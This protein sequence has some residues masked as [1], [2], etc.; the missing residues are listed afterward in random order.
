[1]AYEI[2]AESVEL[3]G[4]A[5]T[6]LNGR[7][8]VED[9]QPWRDPI[10]VIGNQRRS[11]RTNLTQL[12]SEDLRFGLGFPHTKGAVPIEG[13]VGDP[14]YRGFADSEAETRFL[15]QVTLP[16]LLED[17]THE[18]DNGSALDHSYYRFFSGGGRSGSSPVD[19]STLA[20]SSVANESVSQFRGAAGTDDWEEIQD[21]TGESNCIIR[22][23]FMH[24]GVVFGMGGTTTTPWTKI[25]KISA[26]GVASLSTPTT[27]V[28]EPAYS[29]VSHRDIIVTANF[30][31]TTGEIEI[32]KSSDD[33]DTF[34]QITGMQA[35]ADVGSPRLDLVIY[36]DASGAPAVYLHTNT[37]LFLLDFE[38]DWLEEI[39]DFPIRNAISSTMTPPPPVVV[40]GRL[41]LARGVKLIEFHYSGAW[42]D[43]S[44]V[45]QARVPTDKF[46]A[47]TEVTALADAGKELMVAFSG[48]GAV[49]SVWS[50][51]GDGFH[52]ITKITGSGLID[53]HDIIVTYSNTAVN[54][55]HIVYTEAGATDNVDFKR[56]ERVLEEP[57]SNTSKK[58]ESTGFVTLPVMDGGMA[59]VI[60][61]IV[62]LGGNFEDLSADETV[63]ITIDL[64]KAGSFGNTLTYDNTISE[65]TQK[66]ASG[67]GLEANTWQLKMTLANS[68]NT[69]SPVVL[70][71]VSYFEKLF[72]DLN[73]Y[74][75]D[76]DVDATLQSLQGKLRKGAAQSVLT[77]LVTSRKK[78]PLLAFKWGGEDIAGGT[79]P[80]Y[81]RMENLPH[82]DER[83]GQTTKGA[84][85]SITKSFIRVVVAD[86]A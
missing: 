51:T 64:D 16:G 1:M 57:K 71:L 22:A 58:Y 75:F 11:D 83:Q 77:K 35:S 2:R 46:P 39:I 68:T 53:V 5:Y 49:G 13:E 65:G 45:S 21:L 72:L 20:Y 33:G 43:I 10:R 31:S 48:G 67:A 47:A 82:I 78:V 84:G 50:Y 76:I 15:G 52:Y 38:N 36:K 66:Y 34:S 54:A 14:S 59:E 19:V 37:K 17:S 73:R 86:R 30:D 69:N 63:D 62:Q 79:S 70:N 61:N 29:G 4:V 9:L 28:G 80:R 7:I 8:Q 44:P 6:L 60:T 81:V 32:W 3:D 74:T 24:K 55:L 12:V 26:A 25:S 41:Y 18:N 85:Q 56:V 40:N 42:R 27:N 23:I